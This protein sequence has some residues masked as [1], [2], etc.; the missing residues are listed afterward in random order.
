MER[1]S[2]NEPSRCA[3]AF[4]MVFTDELAFCQLCE[5]CW[6][7]DRETGWTPIVNGKPYVPAKKS[8]W[9]KPKKGQKVAELA[10][11]KKTT[12]QMNARERLIFERAKKLG[13]IQTDRISKSDKEME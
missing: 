7:L 13:Q 5:Q 9:N 8:N 6:D 11:N 3:H 1:K 4:S 12:E 10:R 2:S